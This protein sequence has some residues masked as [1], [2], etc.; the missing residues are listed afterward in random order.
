MLYRPFTTVEKKS[1][2]LLLCCKKAT[3][4]GCG[5]PYPVIVTKPEMLTFEDGPAIGTIRKRNIAGRTTITRMTI[6]AKIFLLGRGWTGDE[7]AISCS[8]GLLA[9]D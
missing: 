9:W 3:P 2:S 7:A 1:V 5:V 8:T 4:M 6:I